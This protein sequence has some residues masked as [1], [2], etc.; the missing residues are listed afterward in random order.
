MMTARY[1]KSPARNEVGFMEKLLACL[2]DGARLILSVPSSSYEN[3]TSLSSIV[4]IPFMIDGMQVL[5]SII[6]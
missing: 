5:L 4:L 2:F 3:I 6:M 1:A